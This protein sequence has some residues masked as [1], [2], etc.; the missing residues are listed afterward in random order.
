MPE[1]IERVL[2]LLGNRLEDDA[3]ETERFREY[4]RAGDARQDLSAYRAWLKE[5]LTKARGSGS[6]FFRAFQDI[7]VTLG[8]RLGFSV[9]YDPDTLK[10]EVKGSPEEADGNPRRAG[11]QGCL[12]QFL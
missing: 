6:P 12:D 7:I 2:R 4:L 3:P 5:C 11:G 1:S 10:A 8:Q 9:T